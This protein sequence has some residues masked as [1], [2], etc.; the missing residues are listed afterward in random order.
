MIFFF[1][2]KYF[3]ATAIYTSEQLTVQEKWSW[4]AS[5]FKHEINV[6]KSIIP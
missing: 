6:L 3:L 2:I 5:K 1:F 4:N